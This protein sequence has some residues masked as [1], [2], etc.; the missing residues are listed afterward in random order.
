MAIKYINI[1]QSK[2]LQNLPKLGFLV[3][4]ETIWQPCYEDPTFL[5]FTRKKARDRDLIL[6]G[7]PWLSEREATVR[8]TRQRAILNFTPGTQGWNLS[9][10][11][12]VHPFVHPQG[13]TLLYL[14]EWRGEQREFQPQGITSPPP[15]GTKFT[16]GD[17][18]APGGKVFP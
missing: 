3:W 17:N 18:Y 13:W 12:S 11:G 10:R 5:P 4:K 2:A 16:P 7:E 8:L 9:P 15:R 6:C 14:E 1:I